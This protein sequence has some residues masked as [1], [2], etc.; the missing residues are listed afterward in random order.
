M[1]ILLEKITV[2]VQ[3]F[4]NSQNGKNKPLRNIRKVINQ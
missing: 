2:K 1:D 3:R 4:K